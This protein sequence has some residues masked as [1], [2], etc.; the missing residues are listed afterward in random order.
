M[1]STIASQLIIV[2]KVKPVAIDRRPWALKVNGTGL[3]QSTGERVHI[4]CTAR[5]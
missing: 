2:L 3:T 4:S 1:K 5:V